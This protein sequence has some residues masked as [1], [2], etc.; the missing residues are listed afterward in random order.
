M[1][2]GRYVDSATFVAA[3]AEAF[4]F[5]TVTGFVEFQ[6]KDFSVGYASAPLTIRVLYDP[7]DG[8][9]ITKLEVPIGSRDI[10]AS[11]NCVYVE[12][13]LGPAQHIRDIARSRKTLPAVLDTQVAALQRV[14]PLLNQP[15]RQS[16]LTACHGR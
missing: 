16:I 12:A 6:E 7:F 5:L 15:A 1:P 8:R 11:L 14:L 10:R 4:S 13:G 9:V 2:R 3:A